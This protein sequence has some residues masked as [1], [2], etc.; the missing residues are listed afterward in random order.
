MGKSLGARSRAHPL[1]SSFSAHH[2]QQPQRQRKRDR[3]GEK[4]Q[5]G[6]CGRR[7]GGDEARGRKGPVEIPSGRAGPPAA[8]PAW[9]G[10]GLLVADPLQGGDARREG[11]RGRPTPRPPAGKD[12]E[13]RMKQGRRG[14]C[15]ARSECAGGGGPQRGSRSTGVDPAGGGRSGGAGLL[16]ADPARAGPGWPP[17]DPAWA[18]PPPR[19]GDGGQRREGGTR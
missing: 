3:G 9:E 4:K 2:G 18:R 16:A 5:G 13:R 8:N 10:A 11:Q 15:P 1:V 14:R 7:R 6:W 12:L 17:A 19:P